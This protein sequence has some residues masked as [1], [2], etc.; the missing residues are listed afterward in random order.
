[1]QLKTKKNI[2]TGYKFIPP[3]T[4]GRKL[5]K[6]TQADRVAEAFRRAEDISQAIKFTMK[7][8]QRDRFLLSLIS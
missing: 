8:S 5:V 4:K 3:G 6:Y 1:M 7:R 2:I